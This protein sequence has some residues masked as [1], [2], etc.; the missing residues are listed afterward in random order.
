MILLSAENIDKNY[1]EKPLLKQISFTVNDGDKIGLVG[2]NGTGKSTL[3]KIIA[4]A[5]IPDGGSIIKAG[6]IKISY[7]PQNPEF[8]P[9]K[10]I[11]EQVFL[12]I[13]SAEEAKIYEAKTIL[14][15]TW[16]P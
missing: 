5:E 9:G 11:L 16:H 8:Q 7:L 1:G 3:L 10:T 13:S 15:K 12:N 6:N 14:A 4:Q 2:I